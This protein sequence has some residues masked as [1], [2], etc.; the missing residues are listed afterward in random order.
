MARSNRLTYAVGLGLSTLVLGLLTLGNAAWAGPCLR[1]P[2][3]P[4]GCKPCIPNTAEFGYFRTVW[5]QWPGEQRP[6]IVFPQSIGAEVIST[7]KGLEQVPTPKPAEPPQVPPQPRLPFEELIPPVEPPIIE[8][9]AEGGILPPVI[10]PAQDSIL[11]TLPDSL[12]PYNLMPDNLRKE[13]STPSVPI[14]R[15]DPPALPLDP[16]DSL[17]LEPPVE[18]PSIPG[19][20]ATMPKAATRPL[21]EEPNDLPQGDDPK[22]LKP[23]SPLAQDEPQEPKEPELSKAPET[24]PAEEQPAAKTLRVDWIGA[25]HPGFRGDTPRATAA[26]LATA[27][28]TLRKTAF[29]PSPASVVDESE[30][31]LPKS[32][33]RVEPAVHH[34]SWPKA[35]GGFCP[36]EL[37]THEQWVPGD[38]TFTTTYQ[39]RTYVFAGRQQQQA[40]LADPSRFAPRC[41]GFDPVLLVESRR[42]VEGKTDYCVTYEDRL[43]MFSSPDTLARFQEQPQRYTSAVRK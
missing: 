12:M 39:G 14:P 21:A 30:A 36:V 42:Q 37:G 38:K 17:P 6:D 24:T 19:E 26:T 41:A 5:R 40:F 9:S 10:P 7:P 23:E 2:H 22:P 32:F 18:E 43:Y 1:H 13:P 15:E 29:F 8:P 35:L 3:G 28:R 27:S 11:P 20:G 25:L 16:G 34:E 4:C 33:S 31:P